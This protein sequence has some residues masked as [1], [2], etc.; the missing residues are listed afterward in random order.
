MFLVQHMYQLWVKQTKETEMEMSYKS[1]TCINTYNHCMGGVDLMDQQLD[2]IEIMRKSYKWY[3]KLFLR[4]VMQRAL[5][6]HKLYKLE[7]GKEPFLYFLLDT[8]TQ[9]LQN[10]PRLERPLRRT[11]V[12]NIARLTGRNHWSGKREAPAEWK[13][14]MNKLEIQSLFC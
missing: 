4:L 5:S 12:D 7:N 13:D 6:S 1:P 3:K 14:A 2:G 10:A 9:L 8:C 11:E